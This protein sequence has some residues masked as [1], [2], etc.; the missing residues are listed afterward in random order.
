MMQFLIGVAA[1]AAVAYLAYR[2]APKG[3]RTI[4]VQAAQGLMS[5]AGLLLAQLD[6]FPWTKLLDQKAAYGVL[7]VICV[8]N[9]LLR[10]ATDTSIGSK[11]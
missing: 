6:Q 2:F 4:A 7:L 10:A 5:T 1:A 8:A 9:V 3:W 11:E